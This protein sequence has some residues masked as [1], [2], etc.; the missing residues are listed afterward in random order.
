MF[1]KD[2][3]HA[4]DRSKIEQL[5]YSD[6]SVS[7][8]YAK[9]ASKSPADLDWARSCGNFKDTRPTELFLHAFHD[10]LQCLD[11]DAVANCVSPP[12]CGSTGY[13]PMTIIAPLNDQLRHMSNLIARAKK[14]VLLATNFWKKSG[15]S[16][17]VN[18]ALIELSKRAGARGERAVVKIMFDRGALK[19]VLN[20]HQNVDSNGWQAAGVGIPPPEQMPNVDLAIVNFHRPPLGT[21]HSKFMIVDRQIATVSS[22]N[23]QDN[24]NLEMMTHLEGPIVDS[25]W[26]TFLISWHNELDPALP[27]RTE[28]A[29]TKPPPTYELES[30]T[31][32]F[33]PD[34][35][36]RLPEKPFDKDLPEHMPNEP[37]HD[38]TMSEEI[39]RMRST[40][41]PSSA[42]KSVDAVARHLNKPTNLSVKATAPERSNDLNFFPFIPLP[43]TE[44]VPMAMCSRKPYANLNND[45]IFVPQ[46]EAWLSLMRNA[47]KSIFIQTP[48]L[49]AKPLLPELIKAVKRG[50]VQVTCYVCLGYNDGGEL[51]PGQGGT[52]EMNANHLFS[53]LEESEKENLNFHYYVAADQILPIHNNFRQRSCHI[54]LLIVDEQVAIQGSGNMDTQ[55][56]FHSQEVNVMIDSSAICKAWREGI[57]RNQ[58]TGRYGRASSKDGCWYHPESGKLAE[59]CLGTDAGHFAWAKGVIGTFNKAK[60]V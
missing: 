41:R 12:L 54:K 38:S 30:F 15:A 28:P 57:E 46:N 52:N 55:S 49:N 39:D 60:G 21:F 53:Q 9:D 37:H 7:S 40:L 16:T 2:S 18:D 42:E 8:V 14:E 32:L 23:I 34:G 17:F 48:D 56:W 4:K 11:R 24:D 33:E 44:P 27:C 29:A 35:K 59:G 50:G 5:C 45:S 6:L 36:F 26:E 51:L 22:N 1:S 31:S 25:L 19:Q 58:N 10:L 20:N 3:E 47:K 13:V 43:N